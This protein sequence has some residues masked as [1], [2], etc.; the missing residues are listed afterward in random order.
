M[1][2]RQSGFSDFG[3][4]SIIDSMQTVPPPLPCQESPDC[5]R[6]HLEEKL[7]C[8]SP[9]WSCRWVMRFS[10]KSGRPSAVPDRFTEVVSNTSDFLVFAS[11]KYACALA[12]V[13]SAY[14]CIV[15][16]L[17]AALFSS[18]GPALFCH[19]SRT[20]SHEFREPF[21]VHSVRWG[22]YSYDDEDRDTIDSRV[23]ERNG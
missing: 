10:M 4:P 18:Q 1:C 9:T 11:F 2:P 19:P 8:P 15:S 3:F 12:I 14:P 23:G 5:G 13:G 7:P 17:P 22:E 20:F 16:S 21:H 6:T